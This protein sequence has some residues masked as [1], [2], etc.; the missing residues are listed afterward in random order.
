MNTQDN[1]LPIEGSGRVIHQQDGRLGNILVELGK[2]DRGD[3]DPILEVQ[4]V[5]GLRFGETS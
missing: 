5:R 3:I 1:V 2:I 4:R